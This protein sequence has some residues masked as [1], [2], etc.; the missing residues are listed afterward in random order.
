[1]RISKN[2]DLP[3]IIY[4]LFPRLSKNIF[5]WEEHIDRID[6]MGFNSIYVNPFHATGGSRSLYA[7]KDY[8]RL[9]P[10]FVP[11]GY[12]PADFSILKAFLSKCES[13]DIAVF[14]DLV[15]NHT[16]NDSVLIKEHPQWYKYDNGSLVHPY[17]IDPANPFNVTVWGDLAEINYDNNPDFEGI[18]NYWDRLIAFFQN[19]GFKGFR[20][21]AAYKVPYTIWEPLIASA[22]QR[23]KDVL[24]LA[25]TLGCKLYQIEALRN[26]GFDYLFNS[27]KW[28]NFDSS[29]CIDQHWQIKPIAPSI[30][31][32]ESHD[33]ARISSEPPGTLNWQK[34][35]YVLATVFSKGL[36]MPIGYE[37]GS[38]RSLHVVESRPE[39]FNEQ[40]WD[41][42]D[43][44][45]KVNA[46][47]ISQKCLREEGQWKTLYGYD[48]DTLFLIK[49]SNDH[50][51]SIGM[52]VN[53]DW[54][55]GTTLNENRF[56]SE[57]KNY[58]TRIFLFE[59]PDFIRMNQGNIA[60]SPSEIV[61]FTNT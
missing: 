34:N 7:V 52:L 42:Q 28:W 3:P 44:I 31:F 25:E 54:Y 4:N 24:F 39:H 13:K 30:S 49:E 57:I 15:I 2:Q 18:R 37:F 19:I 53:K 43:W 60:L 35:R 51:G 38:Q 17:A 55:N 32:P 8:Y 41:I 45:S 50:T 6:S 26:C 40:R 1:M 48:C 11:D 12:N 9:N 22:K 61:L 36:L 58:N 5:N 16:S 29:W 10:D 33:T 20:C 23:D 46:F 14:M 59:S 56:P 21:D 47:K 27:S